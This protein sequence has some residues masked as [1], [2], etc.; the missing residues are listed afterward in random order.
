MSESIR[1][2]IIQR[3]VY[4]QTH[5]AV[6]SPVQRLSNLVHIITIPHYPKHAEASHT[7]PRWCTPTAISLG[8]LRKHSLNLLI[9]NHNVLD[10]ILSA[11]EVVEVVVCV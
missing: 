6:D 10:G 5:C 8:L 7:Y 3:L 9:R 4:V 2:A 1:N 11:L